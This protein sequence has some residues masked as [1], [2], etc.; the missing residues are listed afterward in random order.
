V[1]VIGDDHPRACTGR[2]LLRRGLAVAFR[3]DQ[4]S[5]ALPVV[6]DPFAVEPLSSADAPAVERGGLLAVDCSWNRISETNRLPGNG[7]HPGT[8]R[9]LPML[10]ATNPQ[11][12]GRV[13]ELNTAEALGAALCVLGRRAEAVNLL[14][15][16]AGGPVFFEV[17]RERLDR[18]RR[19][20]SSDAILDAEH[21]LFGSV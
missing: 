6:L 2:R 1:L 3:P 21:F 10:L 8:A 20:R 16:F 9:R 14:V 7:R 4:A 15:G 5:A 12:Y 19:A 18:Y 13:G 17:N 11:H